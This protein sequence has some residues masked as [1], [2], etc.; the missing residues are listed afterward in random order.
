[1]RIQQKRSAVEAFTVAACS[2]GHVEMLKRFLEDTT[3]EYC[4]I[5]EDDIELKVPERDFK[6]RLQ[7]CLDRRFLY[8]G[9][10]L[11]RVH[12]GGC[13]LWVP[14]EF[15]DV[16]ARKLTAPKVGLQPGHFHYGTH[17]YLVS[18]RLAVEVI[19]LLLAGFAADAA[20]VKQSRIDFQDPTLCWPSVRPTIADTESKEIRH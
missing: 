20:F 4:Y 2:L 11:E 15:A 17:A 14:P 3:A 7:A 6:K 1:M 16:H 10:K 18:R 5:F 12:F 9:K 8:G 13:S 19:P